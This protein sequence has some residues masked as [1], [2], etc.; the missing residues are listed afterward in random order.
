MNSGEIVLKI[1]D[2]QLNPQ[3]PKDNLAIENRSSNTY[4]NKILSFN[5][6]NPKPKTPS[7]NNSL[8]HNQPT[9]IAPNQVTTIA[10]NPLTTTTS[11]TNTPVKQ[12]IP[13]KITPYNLRS[14]NKLAKQNNI[15]NIGN[16]GKIIKRNKQIKN[17]SVRQFF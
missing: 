10:P 13:N 15:G 3:N 7:N 1:A 16:I 2:L 12:N 4:F 17:F 6:S 14:T 9:N 5:P 11:S 8:I